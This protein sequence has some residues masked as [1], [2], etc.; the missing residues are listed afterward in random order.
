MVR[1]DEVLR[2]HVAKRQFCGLTWP[3]Q[4]WKWK[5]WP[6]K[7]LGILG[8]PAHVSK[9][10]VSSLSFQKTTKAQ[11]RLINIFKLL[12]W[13]AWLNVSLGP[14]DTSDPPLA[15]PSLSALLNPH[16]FILMLECPGLTPWFSSFLRIHYLVDLNQSLTL[17]TTYMLTTYT[18]QSTADTYL[19]IPIFT[20][21]CNRHLKFTMSKS[22]YK[23][24]LPIA[25]HPPNLFLL[26]LPSLSKCQLHS[27][28]SPDQTLGIIFDSALSLIAN[29]SAILVYFI[30]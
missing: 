22:V 14:Q 6:H 11:C 18:F 21:M 17:N 23:Y 25:P 9:P 30:F 10:E 1:Q 13:D 5:L 20:W 8:R 12:S 4:R 7:L 3:T 16:L 2:L 27:P 28:K 26:H 19:S 15:A 29:L 24:S